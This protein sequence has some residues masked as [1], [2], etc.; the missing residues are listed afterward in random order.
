M[1][2]LARDDKERRPD[3]RVAGH[4]SGVLFD[5]TAGHSVLVTALVQSISGLTAIKVNRVIDDILLFQSPQYDFRFDR[6]CPEEM[7]NLRQRRPLWRPSQRKKCNDADRG[8][9]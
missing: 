5:D 8:L 7:G 4:C 6:A 2:A 1:K 3:R 9:I